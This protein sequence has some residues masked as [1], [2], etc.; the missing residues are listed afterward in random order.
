MV[1]NF[2]F[3][4]DAAI[5][6]RLGR[7]L[8]AKQETALIE[9]IKNSYDADAREVN[10]LFGDGFTGEYLEIRDDGSGMG[11]EELLAGFLRLASDL[12]V[13]SPLSPLY[14]RQRAGR[15]GI[16]RFA[17]QRL[18]DRLILVTS[19]G[20]GVGLQLKVD[21]KEFVAG[22]ELNDVTVE[23]SEVSVDFTGTKIKIE[24]LRDDWT[25]SQFRRCWRGV[26]ALQQPFP[27]APIEAIPKRDPGFSVKFLKGNALY[28]DDVVVA[29]IQTEI[30]DHLHAIIEF[31]VGGDG[32]AFWRISKSKFG[33]VTEWRPINTQDR[34]SESPPPYKHLKNAW[35]KAHHVILDPNLL[36]SL[37]YTRVRD[38]LVQHGGIKLYR[39]GF[40]VVPYGDSD[41]DWLGLDEIY[42]RRSYLAP[43]A[44]RNFFGVIEVRDVEGMLFEEHTSREGLIETAALVELVEL[45]S[46]VL[47]TAVNRIQEERGKKVRAG[48]R[49]PSKDPVSEIKRIETAIFVTQKAVER[50][51]KESPSKATSEAVENIAAAVEAVTSAK[52]HIE[53]V[54]AQLAD[55]S[56][57]LRFLATLG[58]TTAEF[59]HETGMTFDAFRFDFQRVFAVATEASTDQKF[60]DQ[61]ARANSMLARLDTLT[62]YLNALAG[63]R[64][65]RGMTALSLSKAVESFAAG[66]ILQAEA[67]DIEL[68]VDVPPFDPLY[69]MPMHEAELASMLLNF[70][71]NAVKALKRSSNVRKI[72]VVADRDPIKDTNIRLRF[73]DSGDGVAI[74]NRDRIFDAFFTTRSAPPSAASDSEHAKGTGL[75]LWIVRQIVDSAS[76]E[77]YLTDP[78]LGYSTC[79]ELILPGEKDEL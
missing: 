5:I 34:D 54:Q 70:Y 14:G 28:T 36:P 64:S 18:G 30:L 78:P 43:F 16:G 76:G 38:E 79:V 33:E 55:E 63:A 57:M 7:E 42:A 13:K 52:K 25:D 6:N 29:D 51:A 3:Y 74:E 49:P 19:N 9:L 50:A 27:V 77:I 65:A 12:K 72:L 47:I 53:V 41:N 35:M 45:A 46:S 8:V 75:G 44:N 56:S 4:A 20:G 39:N 23:L 59:S 58:M 17:T 67:T 71:T 60:L 10:V 22:R 37:V 40:R 68:K 32:Y 26:I 21:W 73:C 2:S 48:S 31:K 62:S 11:R 61:A 15:K 66:I 1:E 69:T 24:E